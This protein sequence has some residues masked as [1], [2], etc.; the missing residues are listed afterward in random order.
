MNTLM[1]LSLALATPESDGVSW[2]REKAKTLQKGQKELGVF[3]PLR[4]GLGNDWEIQTQKLLLFVAPG[5]QAKK[6]LWTW[7]DHQ[8]AGGFGG[9]Y[10]TPLLNIIAKDGIGGVLAPDIQIP[11]TPK[12]KFTGHYTWQPNEHAVTLFQRA[13]W[14]P[15]AGNYDEEAVLRE[16]GF[17][18]TSIDAPMAY[19]R[20]VVLRSGLATQT[21]FV[22]DGPFHPRWHYEWRGSFW[23][24]PG[25]TSS[26]QAIESQMLLRFLIKP[27]RALQVGVYYTRNDFPYGRQWHLLP[28]V[29]ARWAW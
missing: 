23:M 5:A 22:F 11:K 17:P 29:D 21:G 10:A 13:D 28:T 6:Q 18:Y 8:I 25:L 2:T 26:R 24:L 3:G 19:P 4:W 16:G 15:F 12:F 20:S 27:D 14:V 7:G 9:V 1:M